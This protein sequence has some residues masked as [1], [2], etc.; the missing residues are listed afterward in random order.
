MVYVVYSLK[1]EFYFFMDEFVL[2]LDIS[3]LI[4]ENKFVVSKFEEKMRVVEFKLN[5]NEQI[6]EIEVVESLG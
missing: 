6:G 4:E 1:F 3:Y 5:I 2:F